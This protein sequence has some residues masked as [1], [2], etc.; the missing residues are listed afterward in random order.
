MKGSIPALF[1]AILCFAFIILSIIWK[2]YLLVGV[3]F[4]AFIW[5]MTAYTYSQEVA[6]LK[7]EIRER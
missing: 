5:A 6:D 4:V 1:G 7:S 3:W 2:D